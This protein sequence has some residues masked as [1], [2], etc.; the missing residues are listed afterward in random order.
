MSRDDAGGGGKNE[1]F[2]MT[3]FV[4]DPIGGGGG[5]GGGGAR[6]FSMAHMMKSTLGVGGVKPKF[7]KVPRE[8]FFVF[9]WGVKRRFRKVPGYFFTKN[10]DISPYI[11][12]MCSVWC[13]LVCVSDRTGTEN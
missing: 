8:F 9:R 13:L 7:R 3:S 6:T 11:L 10:D 12:K 5:G 2:W 4:N 1:D